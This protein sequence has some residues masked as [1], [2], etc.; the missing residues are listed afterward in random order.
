[1]QILPTDQEKYNQQQSPSF[2]PIDLS[3]LIVPL[4]ANKSSVIKNTPTRFDSHH[5]DC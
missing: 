3:P 4:V 5:Q 1:M 2:Q